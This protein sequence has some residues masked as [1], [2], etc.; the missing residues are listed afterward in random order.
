LALILN[1]DTATSVC[2]VSLSHSGKIIAV[3]ETSEEKAHASKLSVF[4]Q[5]IVK[6]TGINIHKLDAVAVS[7]GPGS[8]TGLRIGVSTAKGICYGSNLPLIGINTLLAMANGLMRNGD[9]K[10]VLYCPM[11]DARRMEVFCAVYDKDKKEIRKTNA[12]IVDEGSFEDLLSENKVYFFGSGA[13][14][15]KH[16]VTH[17]N[18]VFIDDFVHSSV[19]MASLAE[20][21]FFGS[22]F[23]DV[24]YF[25]PFYLKDFITTTPKKFIKP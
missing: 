18:A 1:I 13:E 12:L 6:E 24:A 17:K 23:E 21:L 19:Y 14:K 8:Y 25:E 4:I 5:E 3:K 16:I 22:K 20:D 2:S 10:N 11:I 7:K 9:Y 15:C